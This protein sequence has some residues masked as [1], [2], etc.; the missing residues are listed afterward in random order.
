MGDKEAARR[1]MRQSGVPTTPGT[2]VLENVE[3]AKAAAQ[4][5]GYP[6]MIKASGAI[7]ALQPRKEAVMESEDDK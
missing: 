7:L 5:M 4:S 1:L 2:D 6:V 3:A